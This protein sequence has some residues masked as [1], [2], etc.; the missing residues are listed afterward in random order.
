MHS[1]FIEAPKIVRC[2]DVVSIIRVDTTE[3][4]NSYRYR[5]NNRLKNTNFPVGFDKTHKKKIPCQLR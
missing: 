3:T 4:E 5:H 2:C 1:I